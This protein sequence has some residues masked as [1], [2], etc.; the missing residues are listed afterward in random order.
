MSK[1]SEVEDRT[2]VEKAT[3]EDGTQKVRASLLTRD[4]QIS[5]AHHQSSEIRPMIVGLLNVD[6][7]DAYCEPMIN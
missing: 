5:H 1:N 3:Q 2:E 7:P 6:T 4:D